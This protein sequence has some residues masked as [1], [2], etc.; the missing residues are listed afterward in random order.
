MSRP[1]EDQGAPITDKAQLI[2]WFS[3]GVTPRSDWKVGTEHEKFAFRLSDHKRLPYEGADGIGAILNGLKRFGWQGIE[4]KGK[5]IALTQGRCAITLEPGGQFE[6]SG[7]PLDNLHQTCEEVHTHL[8]Q[9]RE[10]CDELGVGMLGL[11][12]DPTSTR[13]DITWMP[14]GRYGIMSA[15]MP[16]K[17]SLGLDMMKRTCTIQANLDFEDE[18]DMV[19]KYRISLALQPIATALFAN[20]PFT[21]G[22]PNGFQSWRSWVWLDTDND[23][24][25]M[26]PFVFEDGFG[27]ERYVDWALDVPMYFAKRG[28]TYHD[29]AGGDFRDL[30]DGNLKELPGET[31]TV[32][33]W[34]NHLTTLF[35]EVR[36]KRFIEV[37][38]ADGGPGRRICALPALWVGLFYDQASLDGAWDIV[39]DWTT[40]ERQTLREAVPT[41]ALATPFRNRTVRDIARDVIGLARAGLTRRARLNGEG[42]DETM[43]L[44][45]LEEMVAT[46]ETQ[47]QTLLRQYE[48]EWNHEIGRIYKDY[49]Y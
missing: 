34:E 26:V 18:A 8:A 35:P 48:T 21:E 5:V 9:V 10:V 20:S 22:K 31:A 30:I 6:L 14:K 15:Y 12:F 19:E 33:D 42:D 29:V 7:A 16:K 2:E 11:G 27:F 44:S 47:A 49:A 13:E 24:S 46:G 41:T 17:G 1:P 25:G 43:F 37:R 39:R 36:L 28:D 4:E 45:S 3:S 23:R 40:E 38:G 32:S